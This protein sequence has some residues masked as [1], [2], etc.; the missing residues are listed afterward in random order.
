MNVVGAAN[1]RRFAAAYAAGL[2]AY[3][4]EGGEGRLHGAYELGREAIALRLSIVE[5]ARVHHS[6]LEGAITDSRPADHVRVVQAGGDFLAEALSAFEIVHRGFEETR[7]TAA[8]ERRNAVIV[9]RLSA[10]LADTSL[11]IDAEDALDEIIQLVAEGACELT[12]ADGCIAVLRQRTA[13]G[14]TVAVSGSATE[15]SETTLVAPLTALDGR[16]LGALGLVYDGGE[17]ATELDEAVL[18]HLA[19][20]AAAAVD[21]ALLYQR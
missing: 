19:Q 14:R 17:L 6:A 4:R 16:V 21:R 18:A 10:L 20:M 5:L 13:D 9:R 7:E 12:R 2:V 8:V 1:T 3:A 15:Q 11:A